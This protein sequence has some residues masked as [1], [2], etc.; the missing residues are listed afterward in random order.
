MPKPLDFFSNPFGNLRPR[1]WRSRR[2]GWITDAIFNMRLLLNPGRRG[3]WDVI[4]ASPIQNVL[5]I[6]IEVPSRPTA[7]HKVI[8]GLTVSRHQITIAVTE[9]GNRSKFENINHAIA[10][11]NLQLFDWI[12]IVDDDMTT[13]LGLLDESI[14]LAKMADLRLFQ[15][16]HK[17]Q[18]YAA[19]EISHRHWNSLVRQTHFTEIGPMTVLHKS[20]F[21]ALL[22]FPD[23][24]MGYG[25]DV[26]WSEICRKNDWK[27]GIV[28]ATPIRHLNPVARAY[29]QEKAV[30][31]GRGFLAHMSINQHKEEILR[32]VK[33]WR[34]IV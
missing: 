12:V 18:S 13:P 25:L 2:I 31:E 14:F 32:T 5:I 3:L 28:D 27:I 4:N 16:A 20:T 26:Y 29:G 21:N 34:S 19:F 1:T 33:V 10:G 30:E 9:M 23:A 17:F 7:I 6:G 22:P 11:K 15:P 24:G 8:A